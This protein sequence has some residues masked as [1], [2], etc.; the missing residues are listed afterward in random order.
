MQPVAVN[1][2]STDKGT[3]DE[4]RPKENVAPK[5]ENVIMAGD[6]SK[7]T[8]GGVEDLR[9]Q[10]QAKEV[11]IADISSTVANV[12]S[13]AEVTNLN[14]EIATIVTEVEETLMQHQL[15]WLTFQKQLN[16]REGRGFENW[17]GYWSRN[18]FVVVSSVLR[19]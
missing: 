8:S 14:V 9:A 19:W 10:G 6:T 15:Q 11:I 12:E 7:E 4:E 17:A 18:R 5:P 13:Q 1:S 16:P 3:D 2:C